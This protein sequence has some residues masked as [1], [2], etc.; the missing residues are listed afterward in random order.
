M[1][2]WK[3]TV[4][5]QVKAMMKEM[6]HVIQVMNKVGADRDADSIRIRNLEDKFLFKDSRLDT[7]EAKVQIIYDHV[8]RD[9][10]HTPSKRN[11]ALK[12]ANDT[13]HVTHAPSRPPVANPEKPKKRRNRKKKKENASPA[14]V[15]T[16]WVVMQ[17]DSD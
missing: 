6:D 7:V 5:N 4:V 3:K 16:N 11:E 14:A 13:Y 8:L 9:K 12:P 17:S 15:P 10:P 2:L 1:D